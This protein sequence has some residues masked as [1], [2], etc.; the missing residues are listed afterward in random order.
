MSQKGGCKGGNL[1]TKKPEVDEGLLLEL[2]NKHVDLLQNMG[3]YEQI[4]KSQSCN[5]QG[6]VHMLPLTKGLVGLEKTC[7][8]H[9]ACL[10]RAMFQLLVT[11]ASINNSKFNGAVWIGLRIERL[12][13][14]MFHMRRLAK[15]N[16]NLCAARLSG[17][18][19]VQLQ[20]VVQ[21]IEHKEANGQ[22]A[23]LDKREAKD[24]DVKETE[25]KRLKKEISD[26]SVDSEGFPKC[27]AT[28][29]HEKMS[30]PALALGDEEPLTKGKS[31]E[32]LTKGDTEQ[33]QGIPSFLRRRPGQLLAKGSPKEPAALQESL[34]IVA[35]KPAC[36]KPGKKK[37]EKKKGPLAKG[38]TKTTPAPS[39]RKPWT[40]LQ[41]TQTKK[42]PFRIYIC[43]TT[44]KHGKGKKHLIVECTKAKHSQYVAIMSE[45][46]RRL[47]T[48]H[49][50]KEEAINL[51]AELCSTW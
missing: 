28:P 43:G 10:R 4:S 36:K 48:E 35:K 17:A 21:M 24:Q 38:D 47:E 7:E 12:G 3:P 40:K 20:E 19:F 1:H 6:L 25:S 44:E 8:V 18:Q 16:L 41:V 27:F 33:S 39:S 26:V 2:F 51:R 42:P 34:G 50:T 14:I 5:P 30:L 23:F 29:E 11:D 32:P 9:S 46:K 45:I 15:S 22:V 49:L 37:K 13:V 31:K